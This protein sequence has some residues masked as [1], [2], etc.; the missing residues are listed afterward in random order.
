MDTLT[1]LF[2]VVVIMVAVIFVLSKMIIII[3]QAEVMIIE[4]LGRYN[5]TMKAGVNLIIPFL[6][7]PRKVK[8]KIQRQYGDKVYFYVT[9]VDKID[10]RETL[11]DFPRQNVITKDNVTIEIN[12]L[13]YFQVIDPY[14]AVYEIENFPEAIEKLT[15]TTLRNVIGEL[16][17]DETLSSR[18]LINAKLR[19]ILDE[20]TDK[21]GIKINRVELQD[22]L[23]PREIKEAMEKQMRAEREKREMILK[24]EGEKQSK[25]LVAQGDKEA[26]ITRAEGEKQNAILRA[27]GEA[28]AKIRIA[29][30][31][32]EAIRKIKEALESKGT[33]PAQYL[34]ALKYIEAL[35]EIAQ[36]SGGKV[37]FMPYEASSLLSS[38][39]SIKELLKEIK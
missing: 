32:A 35:R 20:A 29:E 7:K 22:I 27:E 9:E 4:R 2:T 34:V 12:A 38:L 31:E 26:Y 16:E 36:G 15:Q 25:I 33:D 24:A 10:L 28:T 17:L 19:S 5:R 37:V 30:A 1:L 21:W 13:L 11:Y 23:P 3:R 8:W 14:K 18:E 6:E 39:G